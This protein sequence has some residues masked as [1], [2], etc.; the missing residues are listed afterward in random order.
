ML[1]SRPLNLR[2]SSMVVLALVAANLL[3]AIQHQ[4]H[5]H[6]HASGDKIQHGMSA[7]ISSLQYGLHG[8]LGYNKVAE[9]LKPWLDESTDNWFDVSAG[10]PPT[11]YIW[12]TNFAGIKCSGYLNT[13]ITG[14]LKLEAIV[15]TET[16]ILE[17]T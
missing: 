12:T 7:A 6:I 9:C 13:L 16:H 8:Y 15:D 5:L 14:A 4:M 1:L 17:A 2:I 10:S 3:F 11:R